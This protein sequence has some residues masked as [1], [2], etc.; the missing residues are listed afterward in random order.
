MAADY[1]N[2]S[3]QYRAHLPLCHT[4]VESVKNELLLMQKNAIN[5]LMN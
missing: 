5:G 4:L 3:R 1:S 2:S